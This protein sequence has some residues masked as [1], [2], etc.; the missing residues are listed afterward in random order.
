M[1]PAVKESAKWVAGAI[2]VFVLAI[3]I[4]LAAVLQ[5]YILG[6]I[7]QLIGIIFD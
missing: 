7:V 6:W 3:G 4:Y 1:N 5:V 2:A